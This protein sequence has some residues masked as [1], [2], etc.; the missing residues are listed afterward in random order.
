MPSSM[1][2][3][4]SPRA[5]GGGG[6][7]QP[8]RRHA[9]LLQGG[10]LVG[11]QRDQRRDDEA[12]AGP[13]QRRDLVAQ[14]LA[15]AGRQ[16]RQRAAPGQHLADH[17]GLQAAEIGVAEG[18][19]QDVA[20]GVERRSLAEIGSAELGIGI[21]GCVMQRA[22][23]GPQ[24]GAKCFQRSPVIRPQ[25]S[26]GARSLRAGIAA[27]LAGCCRSRIVSAAPRLPG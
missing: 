6:G 18:A 2:R 26:R 14:A 1:R 10:D 13:D 4:M 21:H 24:T 11:H 3:Q 19:A 16:H 25:R 7:I 9:R 5:V 15:A 20:R 12:E 22:R 27:R 17:A 8:L 23:P